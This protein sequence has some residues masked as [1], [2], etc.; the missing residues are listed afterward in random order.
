MRNF[1]FPLAAACLLPLAQ[2]APVPTL[3]SYNVVWDSPSADA[4]G[5]MPLGNGDVGI[6]AWVETNGDLCFYIGKTDS[7]GDNGRLLKVGKVRVTL[8]SAPGMSP[9][10][11]E[12][13][14]DDA[15]MPIIRWSTWKAWE[16]SR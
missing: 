3:D 2:A 1:L 10:R 7:W 6:N 8:D 13:S 16:L 14:L 11:Q 15:S 9:F 5:S 12:L 4:R